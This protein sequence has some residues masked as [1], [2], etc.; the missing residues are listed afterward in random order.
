MYRILH[1]CAHILMHV[2]RHE[3][4][5]SQDFCQC[6]I[7]RMKIRISIPL[8]RN[9]CRVGEVAKTGRALV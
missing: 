5:L 9:K 1:M 8:D 3:F 4:A 2:Q 7:F 6:S